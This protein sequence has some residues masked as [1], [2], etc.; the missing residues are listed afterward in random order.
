[1]KKIVVLVLFILIFNSSQAEDYKSY[2]SKSKDF[3]QIQKIE[4]LQEFWP[5]WIMMPWRTQWGAKFDDSLAAKMAEWGYT[6]A[7]QDHLPNK[8]VSTSLDKHKLRWYLDHTAGKGQ[9]YIKPEVFKTAKKSDRRPVNLHDPKTL[10]SIK[11]KIN[12]AV[13][14]SKNYKTRLAYALDDEIS[15]SSFTSPVKWDNN[16]E[17]LAEFSKWLKERYNDEGSLN[18]AWGANSQ[19]FLKKGKLGSSEFV[20]RMATP[21]DFQALYNKPLTEWNLAPWMDAMT[22]QD[23]Y[24]NNLVG[25]LVEY[26]N[27]IDPTVPSGYVGGQAPAPYGGFDYAKLTKKVQFLE[28][29]DIGS[30][31]E[32]VRS[33]NRDNRIATVK[34]AFGLPGSTNI[35]WEN[36]HYLAH[37]DMGVIYWAPKWFTSEVPEEQIKKYGQD[38]Q[39]LSQKRQLYRNKNWVHDGVALYYSHPSIQASWFMDCQPH[40][41]TWIN[42]SSSM[43]NKLAS[44]IGVNWAWQKILEDLKL[45]YNWLG[46]DEVIKNGI[47]EEYKVL[48]LP[49]TLAISKIEAEAIEQFLKRGGTVV[50]DHLPGVFDQHGKSWDMKGGILGEVFGI[51]TYKI[52]SKD[53]FASEIFSE[54]NAD[55]NYKRNF[56]EAGAIE[57]PKCKKTAT[58]Q[59]IACRDQKTFAKNGNAHLLNASIVNYLPLRDDSTKA[60]QYLAPIKA[61]FD[62]AGASPRV[63]VLI[64][65]KE[66]P[67][68]EVT[69]WRNGSSYVFSVMGNPLR[70]SDEFGGK[71][72]YGNAPETSSV[73]LVFQKKGKNA[74]DQTNN[75]KL[76]D[77]KEFTLEWKQP[78]SAI[79]TVDF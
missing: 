70:L 27:K 19:K 17:T 69:Y 29:Y 40:G 49:R 65:G 26:C 18:N 8:S 4:N 54:W 16:P 51:E 30:S 62:N 2:I 45:Q 23:S 72:F 39:E 33:F 14:E 42:R 79:L 61:I 68:V 55:K 20:S 78:K 38:I 66:A 36:W 76:T 43:N 71:N 32:I 59:I 37:G 12:K 73:T 60:K 46:Y 13:T 50:A 34:T 3:R 21:D 74:I 67:N 75:K 5:E 58:G 28:A 64:N 56:I 77:G 1:M 24:Y 63:Q 7:F 10:E 52:K 47:P 44:T 53:L 11:K 6:G 41:K 15:W 9:L 57:W 22:F 35:L 48:I 31:M 25:D